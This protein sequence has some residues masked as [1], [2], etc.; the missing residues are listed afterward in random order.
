M[1]AAYTADAPPIVTEDDST[2]GA[3]RVDQSQDIS[4]KRRDAV[5]TVYRKRG[6][7]IAAHE[8]G[9]DTIARSSDLALY[10]GS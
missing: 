2:C 8:R 7:R 1:A 3:Q 4:S 9:D 5:I 10:Y 6:R